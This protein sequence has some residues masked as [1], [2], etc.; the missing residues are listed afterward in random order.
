MLP[1]DKKLYKL[2]TVDLFDFLQLVATLHGCSVAI[3][4]KNKQS[5]EGSIQAVIEFVTKRG[6]E[7]TETEISRFAW[8]MNIVVHA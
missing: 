8:K 1:I 4:D 7:L 5:A 2:Q 3:C 6:N